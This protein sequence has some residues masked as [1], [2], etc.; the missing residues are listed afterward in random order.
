MY[1]DTR[2]PSPWPPGPMTFRAHDLQHKI[3]KTQNTVSVEKRITK[4]REHLINTIQRLHA[5]LGQTGAHAGPSAPSPWKL[6]Y[7]TGS[8]DSEADL[9]HLGC[10][11]S[12]LRGLLPGSGCFL[13]TVLEPSVLVIKVSLGQSE[14]LFSSFS[15]QLSLWKQLEERSRMK[16]R[17]HRLMLCLFRGILGLPEWAI[18]V[19]WENFIKMLFECIITT[20]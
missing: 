13:H 12:V 7:T 10:C 3:V 4:F 11:G 8:A 6:S 2:H 15:V 1:R 19:P 20:L 14:S 18:R 17:C 16:I 5:L 9:P